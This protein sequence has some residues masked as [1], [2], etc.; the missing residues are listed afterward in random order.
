MPSAP[1]PSATPLAPSPRPRRA[2]WRTW[3]A[4]GVAVAA[5]AAQLA[6]AA[7]YPAAY[8]WGD[9]IDIPDAIVL[10]LLVGWHIAFIP[11]FLIKLVPFADLAPT[12]TV[13]IA[14][15]T[16]PKKSPVPAN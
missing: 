10:T 6:I 1:D 14:I 2:S 13:A 15:A 4:R 3:L 5:D 8:L 16:W 11:S 12:W 7:A 9:I